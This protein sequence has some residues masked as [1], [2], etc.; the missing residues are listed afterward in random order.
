M[1]CCSNLAYNDTIVI[2]EGNNQEEPPADS[3][4][5]PVGLDDTVGSSNRAAP[6]SLATPARGPSGECAP[7]A[8]DA[9]EN[10]VKQLRLPVRKR[11]VYFVE[12]AGQKH[13]D[14]M[15]EQQRELNREVMLATHR[16]T[17]VGLLGR[18]ALRARSD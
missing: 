18:R 14:E 11:P 7:L 8:S 4:L 5:R 15:N 1:E 16:Q 6:L 17:S 13:T 2:R 9:E 12:I 3:Q 10:Q